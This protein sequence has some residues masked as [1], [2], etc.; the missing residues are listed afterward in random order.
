MGVSFV[1]LFNDGCGNRRSKASINPHRLV[2]FHGNGLKDDETV[3]F[4][5]VGGGDW[6]EL[7][8]IDILIWID[9]IERVRFIMIANG[10]DQLMM[11]V[12]QQHFLRVEVTLLVLVLPF[13]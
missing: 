6:I 11:I 12:I 8:Q 13:L 3:G 2:F 1:V 7:S 10:F 4:N 5:H 9:K